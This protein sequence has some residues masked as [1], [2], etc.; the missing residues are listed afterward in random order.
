M[1]AKVPNSDC[2]TQHN[3]KQ[4]SSSSCSCQHNY[5]AATARHAR[6]GLLE[7]P[8]AAEAEV[9]WN[10]QCNQVRCDR[11]SG[12]ECLAEV[13][14]SPTSMAARRETGRES[15]PGFSKC[16]WSEEISLPVEQLPDTVDTE[17]LNSENHR[18]RFG[19]KRLMRLLKLSISSVDSRAST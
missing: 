9:T 13:R 19:R 2:S 12:G 15:A 17:S 14:G 11:L 5:R 7:S 6:Q 4:Q 16:D 10:T 8:T 18:W 1:N 3:H